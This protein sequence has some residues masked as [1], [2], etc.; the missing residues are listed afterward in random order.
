MILSKLV[1]AAGLLTA[2]PALAQHAPGHHGTGPNG[3]RIE[4]GGGYHLE[5]VAKDRRLDVYLTDEAQKAIPSAGYKATA[6]L[7]VV[8][9]PARITL[10]PGEGNRLSGSA[11]G[12]VAA[13]AKGAVR[14]TR[15]DGKT[16]SISFH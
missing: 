4:E 12:P 11:D 1:I 5:L 2:V 6:I 8:G 16:A 7:V 3:G 14:L 13:D 15:P 10:E 9:K